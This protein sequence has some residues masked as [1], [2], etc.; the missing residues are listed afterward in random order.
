MNYKKYMQDIVVKKLVLCFLACWLV[1][2][3]YTHDDFRAAR[4]AL[5]EDAEI[6]IKSRLYIGSTEFSDEDAEIAKKWIKTVYPTEIMSDD[7]VVLGPE[8]S[9]IINS[10]R[11]ECTIV[12]FDTNCG[13]LEV[14][15]KKN[16]EKYIFGVR[17]DEQLWKKVHDMIG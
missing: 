10:E 12:P 9:V 4:N 8:I 14:T 1:H 11:Y 3:I 15:D 2:F 16:G 13:L 17:H 5:D 6:K 7:A